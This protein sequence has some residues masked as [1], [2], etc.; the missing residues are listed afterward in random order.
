MYFLKC[1]YCTGVVKMLFPSLSLYRSDV[2]G[3]FVISERTGLLISKNLWVSG[4][5]VCFHAC[6]VVCAAWR[7]FDFPAFVSA[8]K[9]LSTTICP[10]CPFRLSTVGS[11]F[12]ASEAVSQWNTFCL[13]DIC[14]S[15]WLS[16]AVGSSSGPLTHAPADPTHLHLRH[17][18]AAG[19]V[20]L[21]VGRTMSSTFVRK[22]DCCEGGPSG[23]QNAP[24]V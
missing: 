14:L 3:L 13:P 22:V 1:S 8:Q 2:T 17:R 24:P 23:L 9:G 7:R 4:G 19:V 10:F 16:S 20:G 21:S 15:R 11:V 6:C 18:A 12:S 5:K